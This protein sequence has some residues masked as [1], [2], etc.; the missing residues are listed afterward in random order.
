MDYVLVLGNNCTWY[1]E[2][3]FKIWSFFSSS[4]CFRVVDEKLFS[5]NSRSKSSIKYLVSTNCLLTV[6]NIK[7]C[8][9]TISTTFPCFFNI[10]FQFHSFLVITVLTKCFRDTLLIQIL[11][12]Q[13]A[14][15]S[16]DLVKV[17]KGSFVRLKKKA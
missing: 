6:R 7:G 9:V 3:S 17:S 11:F 5:E 10:F 16:E 2:N 13:G 12:L 14:A 15:T 4:W 8:F 1:F